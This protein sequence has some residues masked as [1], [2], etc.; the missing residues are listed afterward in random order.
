VKTIRG[1]LERRVERAKS[2]RLR[3]VVRED[4]KDPRARLKSTRQAAD[5]SILALGI[6]EKTYIPLWMMPVTEDLIYSISQ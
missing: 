6:A 4:S 3:T 1:G 5:L 2:I